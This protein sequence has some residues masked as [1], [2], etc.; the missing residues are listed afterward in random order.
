M[1]DKSHEGLKWTM[2]AGYGARGAIYLVIGALAFLAVFTA[3]D[4]EGSKGALRDLRA[5]PFGVFMLWA[6]AA[7]MWAYMIWR[8]TAGVVD[9]EDKGSDAKGIF[10]RIAQG[11]TGLIHGAIGVSVATLAMGTGGSGGGAEDW[12]GRVLAMPAGRYLVGAAALILLGAGIYYAYKGWS[13]KYKAHL[14]RNEFTQDMDVVLKFGLVVYGAVLALV[15]LS[16]FY[17]AIYANPQQAGGLGQ[18][19]NSLRGMTFG[20]FL[21]G[22]AGLGL[23]AFALYNFVEAAYRIIPKVSKGDVPTLAD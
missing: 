2:R 8:I 22:G 15:A 7:G 17:A 5:Q 20:Q 10:A 11:I 19:L 1:A 14:A 16:L 3:G 6:I 12:T 9:V 4:A 18:A 21:L 13:G 23:I